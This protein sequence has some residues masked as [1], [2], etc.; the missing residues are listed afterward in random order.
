VTQSATY[1]DSCLREVALSM[2]DNE[3]I[4]D[5]V[6]RLWARLRCDVCGRYGQCQ[7]R[8][9]TRDPRAISEARKG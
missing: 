1:R 7:H 4:G 2:R 9:R 8:D 5:V 3:Q 6:N